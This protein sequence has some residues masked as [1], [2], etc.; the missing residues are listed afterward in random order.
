M[1]RDATAKFLNE[2]IRLQRRTYLGRLDAWRHLRAR[3]SD[4]ST[5]ASQRFQGAGFGGSYL[6]AYYTD[7]T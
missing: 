7:S 5:L 4:D 3:H 6:R 2:V 1:T